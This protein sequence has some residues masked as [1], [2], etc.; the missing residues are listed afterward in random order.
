[1]RHFLIYSQSDQQTLRDP[2]AEHAY[3]GVAVPG[4]IVGY[5]PEA[6]CRFIAASASYFIDLRTPLFQGDTS[7]ARPSHL[8]LASK[9]GT[10]IEDALRN[11]ISFSPGFY[12]GVVTRELVANAVDFQRNYAGQERPSAGNSTS[13]RDSA[14]KR[15]VNPAGGRWGARLAPEY[16]LAPYFCAPSSPDNGWRRVNNAICG[17]AL[18][19]R[20]PGNSPV[21]ALDADDPG[22][23]AALLPTIPRELNRTTFFWLTGFDDRAEPVARLVDLWRVVGACCGLRPHQ[24]VR[25]VFLSLDAQDRTRWI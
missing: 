20:M 15:G 21:I 19:A 1:M 12:S 25:I 10:S 24:S 22:H 17:Y 7:G 4:T 18:L 5:F 9:L 14:Q 2:E 8:A 6:T 13:T 16:V 3:D 11:G 23:L